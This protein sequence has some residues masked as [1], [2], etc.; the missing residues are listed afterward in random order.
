MGFRLATALRNAVSNAITTLVDA[1]SGPGKIQIYTGAQPTNPNTAASG[2]LLATFT[3]A[4]PSFGAAASGTI[5]LQGVP[6]STTG[7]AAGTAGWFRALD[8][9][10]NAVCDGTVSATGGGGQIELNTT[11]VS[12]GLNLQ[13]TSGTITMPL[14]S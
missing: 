6:L 5:T 4:D 12:V 7:L 10:D 9:A 8:S 14:G 3:L 11:T 2:T 1:G 13:I